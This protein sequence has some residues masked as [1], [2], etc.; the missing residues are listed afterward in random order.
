MHYFTGYA[1]FTERDFAVVRHSERGIVP[2]MMRDW[3]SHRQPQV[4]SP[5]RSNCNADWL[6]LAQRSR[7]KN[8][9]AHGITFGDGSISAY[10]SFS[11]LP[12][13]DMR[14]PYL[15]EILTPYLSFALCRTLATE[16][17]SSKSETA[18]VVISAREAEVLNWIK[19]GKTNAEIA[20][21]MGLSPATIKNHVHHLLKRLNVHTRG[22]AVAKTMEMSFA[23]RAG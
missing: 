1:G 14:T 16:T 4:L 22:Q 21:I 17:V 20:Q 8:I 10:F 13:L 23:M 5:D 9:A 18:Q 7:L 6:S 15:L 11:R 2:I 19:Q 12:S 3:L